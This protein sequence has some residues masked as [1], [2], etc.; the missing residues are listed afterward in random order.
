MSRDPLNSLPSSLKCFSLSPSFISLLLFLLPSLFFQMPLYS[1]LSL[2]LILRLF[3]VSL[4]FH[5]AFSFQPS[6]SFVSLH[7]LSR[8]Q[9]LSCRLCRPSWEAKFILYSTGLSQQSLNPVWLCLR[10]KD[11]EFVRESV[12]VDCVCMLLYM[13]M[14]LFFS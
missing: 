1:L 4:S 10:V 9:N 13:H 12:C 6:T 8:F 14:D 3:S 2:L 5:H 11:L 7:F